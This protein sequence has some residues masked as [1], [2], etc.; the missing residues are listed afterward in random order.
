MLNK[1]IHTNDEMFQD[2]EHYFSVGENAVDIVKNELRLAGL[3]VNRATNPLRILDCPSG[4]G[5]VTRHLRNEFPSAEIFA[6]DILEEG[7]EFC[8][9]EFCCQPIIAQR[10]PFDSKTIGLFD[11]VWCGSLITHLDE[12]ST[13]RYLDYFLSHLEEGGIL[14]ATSLGRYNVERFRRKEFS[15]YLPPESVSRLLEGYDEN[16]FGYG[17]HTREYNSTEVVF[18]PL[19]MEKLE[20]MDWGVTAIKPSWFYSFIDSDSLRKNFRI[21]SFHETLWDNNH[22]VLVI[23]RMRNAFGWNRDK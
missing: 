12:F 10:N 16:G 19:V 21:L 4:Y 5:R 17:Q 23:Q 9:K 11:L 3:L 7:V 20:Y 14:V 15:H 18:T 6:S 1:K 8:V 22:D 13:K 2:E